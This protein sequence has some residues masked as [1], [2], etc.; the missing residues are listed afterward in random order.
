[1]H[2]E[3]QEVVVLFGGLLQAL[4][5]VG[6]LEDV[7]LLGRDQLVGERLAQVGIVVDHKNLLQATHGAL[8]FGLAVGFRVW[9]Q[10]FR[11]RAHG[12]VSV[13]ATMLHARADKGA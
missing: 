4:G 5:A 12:T 3:D 11:N 7:E 2:I 6:G 10:Y 1:A 8:L 13:G 9:R